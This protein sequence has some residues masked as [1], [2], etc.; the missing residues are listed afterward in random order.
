L[1]ALRP[2]QLYRKCD[3][4]SFAFNTT[5]ELKDLEELP[6]QGRALQAI[7]FG[8]KIKQRGYN[9]FVLGPAGTGRHSTVTKLLTEAAAA[10]R[11]V[12]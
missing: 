3:P 8:T 1:S 4:A 12:L 9:L 11:V 5:D 6:S 2:E 10:D 7:R